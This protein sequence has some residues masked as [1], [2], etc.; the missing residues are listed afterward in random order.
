MSCR[1]CSAHFFGS[2]LHQVTLSISKFG[3][4]LV[5]LVL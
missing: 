4:H 1:F 3:L 2:F 5:L